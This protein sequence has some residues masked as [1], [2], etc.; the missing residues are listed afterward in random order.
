M[1]A[2]LHLKVVRFPGSRNPLATRGQIETVSLLVDD[3][4]IGPRQGRR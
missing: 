1:L 4:T 2:Y 3:H